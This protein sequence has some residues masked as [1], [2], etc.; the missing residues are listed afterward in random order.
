MLITLQIM[1]RYYNRVTER[2]THDSPDQ[3]NE[4]II[5]GRRQAGRAQAGSRS[6]RGRFEE[7]NGRGA[8]ESE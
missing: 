6:R 8:R 7:T 4:L 5:A 1:K 3:V 2:V